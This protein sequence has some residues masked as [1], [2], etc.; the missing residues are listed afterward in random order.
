MGGTDCALVV[1]HWDV[2]RR[3]TIGVSTGPRAAQAGTL[4]GDLALG[5]RA[6]ARV[7]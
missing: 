6:P 7:A 5:S 4:R 1:V 3:V 2:R